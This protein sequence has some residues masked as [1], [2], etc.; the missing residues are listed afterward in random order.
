MLDVLSLE[1]NNIFIYVGDAVRWDYLPDGV[2]NMGASLRTI[3]ASI[4]SPTSFASITTGLHPP[5]HGVFSFNNQ[6]DDS[7]LR[8][9]DIEEYETSF[10][11]SI[12]ERSGKE[13][14]IFN[15]LGLEPADTLDPFDDI[16]LPF[17]LMERGPGGHA[18]YG[19]FDG[20]AREYFLE[21]GQKSASELQSEYRKKVARDVRHFKDRVSTLAEHDLIEDTLIIYTSDHGE[22]LGEGGL[23]GHTGPMRPEL[24][25]VPTV[26]VH[27]HIPNLSISSGIIR[28]VDF[29][30]TVLEILDLKHHRKQQFDGQP[31]TE[32]LTNRIG[33]AFYESDFPSEKIPYLSG[34]LCYEGVWDRYGGHVFP[35]TALKDR[36]AILGGKLLKSP[37]RRF[38]RNHLYQA[39]RSYRRGIYTYGNPAISET[40]AFTK[41]SDARKKS[42]NRKITRLSAEERDQ[43]RDL[44]YL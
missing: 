43:L 15:V 3:T 38:M 32:G 18:P 22:L 26:F 5:S 11:S 39:F 35:C 2:A 30:P 9:F 19:D 36:L 41:C 4:H 20:T 23:L 1:V 14:P 37:K 27:P 28:H 33:V 44:G 12:Q 8:I 24:V 10:I 29:L 42:A 7:V 6:I 21:N 34:S 13:D 31:I 17:V 25:Y 40:D 16:P